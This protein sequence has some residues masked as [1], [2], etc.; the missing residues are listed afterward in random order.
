MRNGIYGN[1]YINCHGG[2]HC[3]FSTLVSVYQHFNKS[4]NEPIVFMNCDRELT[5][6]IKDADTLENAILSNYLV[7]IATDFYEKNDIHISLKKFNYGLADFIKY[8]HS[9]VKKGYP[10]AVF[11]KSEYLKYNRVFKDSDKRDLILS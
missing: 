7:R 6:E 3:V 9:C 2:V 10:V 1:Y 5:F 4:V 11:L 8:V